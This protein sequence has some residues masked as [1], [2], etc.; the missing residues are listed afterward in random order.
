LAYEPPCVVGTRKFY[1]FRIIFV[2][3]ELQQSKLELTVGKDK[4][5]LCRSDLKR[6]NNS[7]IEC[8]LF[9]VLITFFHHL[10]RHSSFALSSTMK[11]QDVFALDHLGWVGIFSLYNM[12]NFRSFFYFP[13]KLESIKST[14]TITLLIISNEF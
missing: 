2:S 8:H 12:D 3:L 10:H 11:E 9:N 4:H 1:C 13:V 14:K 6:I 7:Q 5:R